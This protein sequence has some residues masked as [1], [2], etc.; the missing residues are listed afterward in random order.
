MKQNMKTKSSQSMTVLLTGAAGFVG[1]NFLEYLYR[2]YPKYKF[3]V[4][5]ALTYAGDVKNIAPDIHASKRFHFWYGSVTNTKLVDHLVSQADAVVHFAA[6]THVARS[7]FD[8][9]GFFDTDVLGTQC[10]ANAVLKHRKNIKRF[11]H[12]S[13]SEVYGTALDKKMDENHPLNPQSPYAA[14]KAGADR[15]VYSYIATYNIPAVIVRPFN[16]F[17]PHQHLEKLIPRFITSALLKEPLTVHGTGNS[18]RDFNYVLDVVEALD[19]ILHAPSSKVDGEVLNIATGIDLSVNEIA[20]MTLD[21][22]K[23][24]HK[25]GIINHIPSVMNIGDRPGQVYRHTGDSTKLRKLL[26]WKPKYNFEKGLKETIE[27]YVANEAWWQDKIWMRHVP[28]ETEK[29]KI[30]MH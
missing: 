6:E 5:D 1:S 11:I 12:I 3:I 20:E 30:E 14:A 24:M 23:V 9:E 17:G 10:V 21:V 7:I 27:W 18:A 28:I 15:L 4:L 8:D 13:T 2:K 29:G 26:G 16:I 19:K 22:M 25:K